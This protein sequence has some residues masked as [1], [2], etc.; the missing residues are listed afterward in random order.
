MDSPGVDSDGVLRG[1]QVYGNELMAFELCGSSELIWMNLT[2][3]EKGL[4]RIPA[5]SCPG[6]AGLGTCVR[7]LYTE[8]TGVISPPG[9][10]GHLGKFSRELRVQEFLV[11]NLAESPTCPF[12]PPV[13]PN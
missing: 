10:Y 12:L 4:D 5:Q 11:V 9:S 1:Y 8:L 13:Y 2:G 3:W 7:D 6:D